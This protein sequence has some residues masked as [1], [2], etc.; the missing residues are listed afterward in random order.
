MSPAARRCRSSAHSSAASVGASSVSSAST[1]S[2][3]ARSATDDGQPRTTP[4]WLNS[5]RSHANGA[6]AVSTTGM[7]TVA[8]RTAASTAPEVISAASRGSAVS[9]HIGTARRSS[10]GSGEDPV[11]QPMPKPSAFTVP[12][13]RMS[14]GAHDWRSSECAGVSSRSA[15]RI[16]SPR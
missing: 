15:S 16:G 2:V 12:P 1:G 9:V 3:D 6:E 8:E 4:L 10:A 14:R 11:Y 13:P 5:H 7:P